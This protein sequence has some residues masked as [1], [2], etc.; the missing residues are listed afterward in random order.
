MYC[1]YYCTSRSQQSQ[2]PQQEQVVEGDLSALPQCSP[3]FLPFYPFF[4]P[5]EHYCWMECSRRA[6]TRSLPTLYC[7][8]NHTQIDMKRKRKIWV[9]SG[10]SLKKK[11]EKGAPF[12]KKKKKRKRK[13][14]DR[15][16]SPLVQRFYQILMCR[17]PNLRGP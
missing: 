4:F 9:R 15:F 2:P 10:L 14:L 16:F 6:P 17:F 5:S 7:C 1:Y 13:N 12:F 8:R 11:K 3:E